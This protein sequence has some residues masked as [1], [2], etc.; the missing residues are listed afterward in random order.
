MK[1]IRKKNLQET[2][3]L[4]Y[5]PQLHWMFTIRHMV[6][7]LP[8]FLVLLIAWIVIKNNAGNFCWIEN[9]ISAQ[10][11][12]T[13]IKH[14]FLVGVV[15][16]LLVFVWRI[17]QY[18]NTEYGVTNKRLIIKKGVVCVVITEIPFDRIES[19]SCVQGVFGKAL[20]YGSIYVSGVGGMM[21]VFYMVSRPLAL[22]R[23]IVDIIEKNKV[24]TVINGEMPK[25]KRAPKPEPKVEEEPFFRYGTFVR[26]LPENQP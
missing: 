24:I 9:P 20:K 14:L 13:I 1:F 16:V 4:L 18:L 2:E 26:V 21:P 22:R 3:E 6:Q 10:L 11:L 12:F 7:S 23:K 15:I 17:F 19:I 5:V 25:T 8:F